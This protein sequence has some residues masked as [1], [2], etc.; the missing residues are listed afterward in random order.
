MAY[1]EVCVNS[2]AARRQTFSYSIPSHLKVT[3]GQA[4]LVPFGAQIL[5]GIVVRLTAEPAVEQTRDIGGIVDSRPLLS[6]ERIE[7]ARW[8]SEYYLAPIFDAVALFLPPGFERR[9]LTSV[10]PAVPEGFDISSLTPDQQ[11]VLDAIVQQTKAVGTAALGRLFG[12]KKAQQ[13]IG[14][15][16]KKHLVI[17]SYE[18]E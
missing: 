6:P 7:L 13:I 15:L 1:A 14:Q 5:Q 2:P 11:H 17:K 4:V 10:S 9:V 12:K 8:I 18:L 3:E 16:V